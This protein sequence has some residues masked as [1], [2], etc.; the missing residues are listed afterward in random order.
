MKEFNPTSYKLLC[1][2]TGHEFDDAGWTLDD[3]ECDK[4]ALVRAHYEKSQI[5]VKDDSYGLYKFADWLPVKRMLKGSTAPVSAMTFF[6]PMYLARS[7]SPMQW[8]SLC[9]PV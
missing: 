3:K 5:E 4:P 1:V 6:L 8:L 9:A 7:A 2:A